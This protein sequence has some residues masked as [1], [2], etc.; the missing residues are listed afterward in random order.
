[1]NNDYGMI[2][3]LVLYG[4]Y[5]MGSYYPY[6]F[7]QIWLLAP[8]IFKLMKY[9]MFLGVWVVLM[10]TIISNYVLY[11]TGAPTR[12]E[13]CLVSRYL[14]LAFLAYI[15]YSKLDN[16]VYRWLLPMISIAYWIWGI[17]YDMSPWILSK[18][19]W[20][21]H[22]FP[23]LFYTLLAVF[24]L[25]KINNKLPTTIKKYL[26]W[27]GRYSYSIFIAQMLF[28]FVLDFEHF[29][30]IGNVAIQRIVFSLC[31]MV[32]SIFLAFCYMIIANRINMRYSQTKDV[33]QL[34]S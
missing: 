15:W 34:N 19:G 22:Q 10:V 33:S 4:G 7:I 32:C 5:G 8:F 14:L 26:C 30:F 6:L 25:S 31:A 24:L 21:I 13:S 16:V 1:M 11:K 29:D 28:F 2:K 9:N 12:I 17:D 20:G 3:K 27:A 18:R 23:A